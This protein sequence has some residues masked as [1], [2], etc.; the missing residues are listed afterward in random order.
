MPVTIRLND[1]DLDALLAWL[2]G[3]LED[4]PHAAILEV[5]APRL[6]EYSSAGQ[7]A[8]RILRVLVAAHIDEP[9]YREEWRL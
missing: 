7:L 6:R 9:G 1:E 4:D 3:V 2:R 8:R 5:I